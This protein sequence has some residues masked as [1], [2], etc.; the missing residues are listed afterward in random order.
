MIAVLS[1]I[2]S[3]YDALKEVLKDMEKFKISK[4]FVLGDIIGY[5]P[6]PNK[7]VETVMRLRNAKVLKG[8]HERALHN[9]DFLSSFNPLAAEIIKWTE[10]KINSNNA[11]YLKSLPNE[12]GDRNI[13]CVH[14]S[15]R[16]P[17]RYI[18]DL[19]D[20]VEEIEGLRK[21]N[22]KIEFF[23]HTHMKVIF[24]ETDGPLTLNEDWLPLNPDKLYLANPGSVGQPRDREQ[25]ASYA[26]FDPGKYQ[27]IFRKVEYDIEKVIRKMQREKFP[28]FT[29]NR[30][31]LGI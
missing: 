31:R 21:T 13:L 24:V 18:I 10:K 7:C 8:N 26:I 30:F 6:E 25:F 4:V 3:N 19:P 9:Y 12:F 2:H 17:D 16:V 15:S 29:Y 23:G 27:I 11:E 20:I 28:P 14:G 1:D 5:G 22:Y